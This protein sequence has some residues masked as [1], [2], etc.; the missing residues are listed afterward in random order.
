M[1]NFVRSISIILINLLSYASVV[2]YTLYTLVIELMLIN[3]YDQYILSSTMRT[4]QT[5]HL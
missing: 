5:C 3:N 1:C 2:A 4:A